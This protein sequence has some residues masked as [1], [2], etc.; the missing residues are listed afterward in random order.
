MSAIVTI[1]ILELFSKLYAR[2][3]TQLHIVNWI[4]T[5]TSKLGTQN[6]DP[7]S[8]VMSIYYC[9]S[10]ET[11]CSVVKVETKIVY[12]SKLIAAAESM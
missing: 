12:G 6:K 8:P 1:F 10:N 5:S 2:G 9:S 11:P 4:L 7:D 3:V